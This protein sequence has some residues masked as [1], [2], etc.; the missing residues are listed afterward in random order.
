MD[1]SKDPD[2]AGSLA[3]ST[4]LKSSYHN[5]RVVIFR[6]VNSLSLADRIANLQREFFCLLDGMEFTIELPRTHA[7]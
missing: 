5:A 6:L 3:R 1:L 7:L 2:T 4:T